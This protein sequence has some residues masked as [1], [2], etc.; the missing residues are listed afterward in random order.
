MFLFIAFLLLLLLP[1]PWNLVGFVAGLVLFAG[2]VVFWNRR[3]RG[4]RVRAGAETLIGEQAVAVS[5]CRPT[6]QV[7]LRGEIWDARC[8]GGA[9]T[10]D[11]VVVTA[12]DDLVL[13]VERSQDA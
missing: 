13:V 3:V 2:E 7:R 5:E 4:Q 8:D 12:R 9:E 11:A 10:G 1:D 6:G